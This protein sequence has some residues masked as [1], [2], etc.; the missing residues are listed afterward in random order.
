MLTF[1]LVVMEGNVRI[2]IQDS[3]QQRN[4]FWE[5]GLGTP[6]RDTF[7]TLTLGSGYSALQNSV[8]LANCWQALWSI[9]YVVYNTLFTTLAIAEEWN[10]YSAQKKGLRVSSKRRGDQRSTYFLQLPYRYSLP[11]IA[12]SGLLHWLLSQSVF[13]VAL[14][15]YQIGRE[16]LFDIHSMGYLTYVTCGYSPLGIVLVL[17]FSFGMIVAVFVTGMRHLTLTGMPIASSCSVA[18]AA[19]CHP[20]PTEPDVWEKSLRWGVVSSRQG[21]GHCAF[22]SAE[23]DVLEQGKS[24]E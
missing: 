3:E 1:A 17:L 22:S 20:G 11:L 7:I 16:S 5:Y 13:V 4:R 14:D 21:I 8:L 10:S 15:E 19:A 18:I 23:V 6:N 12:V 9:V 24:Y 2:T